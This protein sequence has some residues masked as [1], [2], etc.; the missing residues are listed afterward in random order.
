MRYFHGTLIRYKGFWS[1]DPVSFVLMCMS[2]LTSWWVMTCIIKQ[3]GR[4]HSPHHRPLIWLMRQ[5]LWSCGACL[6]PPYRA[7]VSVSLWSESLLYFSCQ[8]LDQLDELHRQE[9]S[10]GRR[11]APLWGDLCSLMKQRELGEGFELDID[12]YMYRKRRRT[13]ACA[14]IGYSNA[15]ANMYA[16]VFVLLKT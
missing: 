16:C 10:R 4:S 2:M 1:R 12:I 7:S 3:G 5:W 13:N 6:Q 15:I 11:I 8:S 14:N 9:R